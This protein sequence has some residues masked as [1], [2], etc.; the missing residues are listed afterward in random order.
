MDAMNRYLKGRL[1]HEI[2]DFKNST[3]Y[4]RPM[5]TQAEIISGLFF[6]FF[7]KSYMSEILLYSTGDS[8]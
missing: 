5:W 4:E 1:Y 6:F 7:P 3:F 2:K 8:I